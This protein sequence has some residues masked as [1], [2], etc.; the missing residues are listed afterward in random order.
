[1]QLALLRTQHTLALLVT[2]SCFPFQI[3][4]KQTSKASFNRKGLLMPFDGETFTETNNGEIP[5]DVLFDE[6]LQPDNVILTAPDYASFVKE[7]RSRTAKEYETKIQSI[8]KTYFFH[9][10]EV[11][12]LPDA[13]ATIHYGPAFAAS[14][15]DLADKDERVAG[16]I[17]M[18]TKP[19]NPYI[20]F[21]LMAFA[22]G[23]Q[24][25]RNHEDTWSKIPVAVQQGLK[26]GRNER[27]ARKAV[28]A[29]NGKPGLQLKLPF[30]KTVNLGIRF[31]FRSLSKLGKFYRVQT[32]EPN[33]LVCRVFSDP[34]LQKALEKKGITI[35]LG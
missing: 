26:E 19:D 5:A 13:A 34:K 10:L 24:L 11:H 12:N 33:E 29:A 6:D 18:L 1:V 21:G 30:G 8:L 3:T 31:R 25:F 22:F 2:I 32:S 7:T 4:E 15:G 14:A 28:E 17:D 27:K 35:R 20:A 16:A 23:S 9:S